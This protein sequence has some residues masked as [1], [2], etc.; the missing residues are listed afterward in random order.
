MCTGATAGFGTGTGAAAFGLPAAL[1][2]LP[3]LATGLADAFTAGFF[4]GL[5]FGLSGFGA[6]FVL[7]TTRFGTGFF[8]VVGGGLGF[9]TGFSGLLGFFSALTSP[10]TA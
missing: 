6:A 5:A 3:S 9:V 7:A 2:A 8:L 4:T 1:T 10:L